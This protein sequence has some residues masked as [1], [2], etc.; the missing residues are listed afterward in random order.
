MITH[1][2]AFQD[3]DEVEDME[4]DYSDEDDND[5][6]DFI[7]SQID[8]ESDLEWVVVFLF[9]VPSSD[10]NWLVFLLLVPPPDTRPCTVNIH[11]DMCPIML[12]WHKLSDPRSI[13]LVVN[14][15]APQ[16]SLTM[17]TTATYI[18][19]PG[20]PGGPACHW[21]K[22][23]PR[24]RL[25]VL[26]SWPAM[27]QSSREWSYH[28]LLG[29]LVFTLIHMRIWTSAQYPSWSLLEEVHTLFDW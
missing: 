8:S 24:P 25:S 10:I 12:Q 21:N 20:P 14:M 22:G 29:S 27:S 23:Y 19:T 1:N 15:L 13:F 3:G 26:V 28:F 16:P 6:S 2:G 4:E 18:L 9:L 5:D 7:N 17:S 11:N